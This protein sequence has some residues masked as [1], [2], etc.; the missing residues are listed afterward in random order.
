MESIFLNQV[1]LNRFKFINKNSV[2]SNQ[3]DRVIVRQE[4]IYRKKELKQNLEY[5]NL[6][7]YKF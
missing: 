3:N 4:I 6:N 1:E 5:N 7:F 2:E